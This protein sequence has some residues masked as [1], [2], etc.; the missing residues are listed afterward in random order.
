MS[1]QQQNWK[2][3][4]KMLTSRFIFVYSFSLK[5][6]TLL[7]L[8]P[9]YISLPAVFFSFASSGKVIFFFIETIISRSDKQTTSVLPA[10][11]L[12][13]PNNYYIPFFECLY[14]ECS[15]IC[16]FFFPSTFTVVCLFVYCSFRFWLLKEC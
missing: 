2:M 7:R 12:E 10:L 14:F 15:F 1:C 3:Y 13:D 4:K 16:F 6:S 11:L 5:P 8:I 9:Q